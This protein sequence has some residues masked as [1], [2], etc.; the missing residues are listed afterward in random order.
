[1]IECRGGNDPRLRITETTQA[2]GHVGLVLLAGLC[3]DIRLQCVSL[4]Q[5]AYRH[6]AARCC[7]ARY[8]AAFNLTCQ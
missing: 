6:D 3:A 1:M 5:S 7:S 2:V 4:V 8:A